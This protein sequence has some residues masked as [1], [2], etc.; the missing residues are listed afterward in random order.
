MALHPSTTV[1]GPLPHTTPQEWAPRHPTSERGGGDPL[2]AD[3]PTQ[4]LPTPIS[5]PQAVYPVGLNG[6]NEPIITSLP[7]PLVS[8]VSLT[9]SKY[10]NLGIDILSPPV[11]EPDQKIPPLCEVSTILIASPYKSPLKSEGSMTTE[12]SNLLS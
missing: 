12:V 9:T 6:D 1:Q 7:E 10:I 3:Q 2:W 5:L 4:G 8:G 11:E